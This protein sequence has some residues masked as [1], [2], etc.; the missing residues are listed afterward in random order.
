MN[1]PLK[2]AL[3]A[4]GTGLML[5]VVALL[6]SPHAFLLA[7]LVAAVT[8][9]SL[10]AGALAVLLTTYLVRGAWT[11]DLHI[12]LVAAAL[13]LP[14]AGALFLPVL[15]TLPWNYPWMTHAPGEPGSLK[16]IYLAPGAFVVR[17][18]IYF[19]AWTALALSARRAWG[20]PIRMTRVASAGLVIYAL[21]ASL[22]GIDWLESLTP[23]FHSSIYGLLFV[24]SQILAGFALALAT[25]LTRPG[26]PTHRYG[27]ILLAAILLWAY[28]HAMQYIIIWSGNIPQETIWYAR[29]EAAA[30]GALLWGLLTLQFILPFFAMLAPGMRGARK[31]LLALAITTL[32]LRPLEV[33]LLA[34][35]GTEAAPEALAVA[36][37]AC[38]LVVGT[39]WLM[40]YS[41]TL[42]RV[43]ASSHDLQQL[44]MELQPSDAKAQPR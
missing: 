41:T 27:A 43:R 3:A 31:P 5:G 4:L 8:A 11:E 23:E 24:T 42:R 28:N 2:P 26:A 39:M 21:T 34:L 22:A 18:F 13:T 19:A 37:L 40:A 15:A 10:A 38:L 17:S 20:E 32:L 16:S 33:A 1:V 36:M 7:Y 14:V 25:A 9:T 44:P 29:R 30:W 12:P 35:P 6:R